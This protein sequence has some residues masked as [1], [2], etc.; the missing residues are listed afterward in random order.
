MN[1]LQFPFEIL[2][3]AEVG[4]QVRLKDTDA[5]RRW[6]LSNDVP[7]YKLTN[8][9]CVYKL[10]LQ[11]AISKSFILNL[12]KVNPFNWKEALK[13][14]TPD[15]SMYNFFLLKLGEPRNAMAFTDV[16]PTNETEQ[17]LLKSILS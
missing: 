14:I 1:T 3:I 15:V 4:E 13:D 8:K 11:Y 16:E 12:Q 6:C 9:D 17:K 5:T 2:T 10:D 7:L